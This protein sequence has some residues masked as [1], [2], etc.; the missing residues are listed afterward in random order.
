MA[1]SELFQRSKPKCW[2]NELS[3]VGDLVE[4]GSNEFI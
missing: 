2:K 1:L 3:I 4:N